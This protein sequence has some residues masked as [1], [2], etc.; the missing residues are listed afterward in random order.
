MRPD[1]LSLS[2]QAPLFP[3]GVAAA[4]MP[5]VSLFVELIRTRPRLV[6][7]LAVLAQA[8]L[9][10]LIPWLFYAAPP[11]GVADVIAVGYG[12][13]F[14]TELG[15][16]L[17]Y[18]AAEI[19]FRIGGLL[20]VYALSQICVV[21]TFWA[22][23]T[24]GRLIVGEHHAVMATLLMVGI[25]ALSI[26]TPDFGPAILSM[27]LWA[28]AVL[29]FYRAI[30]LDQRA[31]W[32]ALAVDIG[33]LLLTTYMGAVLVALLLLY[34]VVTGRGVIML[35]TMHPWI[36]GI[37]VVLMLFPHLVWID[38][39]SVIA[40]PTLSQMLTPEAV[41]QNL[42]AWLRL[43]AIIV[44]SH[45]GLFILVMVATNVT[46]TRR[47]QAIAIHRAHPPGFARR[48]VYFFA[49]VPALAVTS[50]LVILGE[51]APVALTPVF[52]LSGLAIVT[53]SGDRI[54]LHH[55]R[56]LGAAWLALLF[57]PPLLAAFAVIATPWTGIAL[58]I[59]QPAAAMAQFLSENYE[60]RTGQPLGVVGGDTRLAS[61]VALLAESR[62][63]IFVDDNAAR[64]VKR[65]DIAENGAIIVWPATDSAG[66]PPPR[67][68]ALFPDL[69]PEVPRVFGR[70]IEGQLAPFRIG[71]GMIRPTA[72]PPA[73]A[74]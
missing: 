5:T 15:P 54:L 23:F 49:I 66:T 29:H 34:A 11:G 21:V 35:R 27:P 20:G 18:W 1:R 56:V 2:E 16:P 46:H 9:W 50:V 48:F 26:P 22:V 43:A 51:P 24:L 47:A 12:F 32:Y 40:L 39:A 69:V 28:L 25:T 57:V 10:T 55:Q 37:I 62:P 73:A 64:P 72:E 71:W 6:F 52:V 19:A 41:D 33:L 30:G 58:R 59:T 42:Y 14:G 17:A 68:K 63:V 60:R 4:A 8:L 61:L 31:F 45:V 13:P 36:A 65:S 7:W 67:V 44:V 3:S 38:Q 70:M 53:A 74:Q